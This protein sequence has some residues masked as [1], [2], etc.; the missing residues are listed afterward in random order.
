MDPQS[1]AIAGKLIDI[2]WD[3]FSVPVKGYIARLFAQKT[4]ASGAGAVEL[5]YS[6]GIAVGVAI[7]YFHN[8]LKPLDDTI[9]NDRLLVFSTEIVETDIA[10]SIPPATLAAMGADVARQMSRQKV[11][12]HALV[13]SY[14]SDHFYFSIIYP[15]TLDNQNF[16]RVNDYL[17]KE[18]S[19]GSYFNRPNARPYGINYRAFKEDSIH[20]YDYARPIEAIWK[21][22]REDKKLSQSELEPI[23]AEEIQLFL[24]VIRRLM[25]DNTRHLFS[26]AE[27]VPVK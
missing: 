19:K 9:A 24:A 3:T 26:N 16:N 14:D 8:F 4:S 11:E 23:Q 20:I 17:R 13:D 5:E 15:Q 18:T 6:D 22:Y 10:A 12:K 7:G 2:A 21:Y 27:F 1:I 25:E